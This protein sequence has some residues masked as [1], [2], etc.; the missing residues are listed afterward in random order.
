MPSGHSARVVGSVGTNSNPF[1][2]GSTFVKFEFERVRLLVKWQSSSSNEFDFAKFEKFGFVP[3]LGTN[4]NPFGFGSTFVK[5][6][7]E[8]V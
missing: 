1:R 3:T 5:F 2:F 7:F 8:R 6:E 4:S